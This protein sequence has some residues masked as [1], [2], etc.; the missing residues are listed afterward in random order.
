M[1]WKAE[2]EAIIKANPVS[3]ADKQGLI[4]RISS[5]ISTYPN[6][7]KINEAKALKNKYE[8]ELVNSNMNESTNNGGNTEEGNKKSKLPS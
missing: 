1:K 3:A 5:F 7:P 6:C 4:N 8:N 2:W